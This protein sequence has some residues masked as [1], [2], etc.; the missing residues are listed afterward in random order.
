MGVMRP[1][2]DPNKSKTA[3]IPLIRSSNPPVDVLAMYMLK[4]AA[5][6][7]INGR[8]YFIP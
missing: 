3:R 5:I 4:T 8:I 6:N 2:I 1:E 7:A